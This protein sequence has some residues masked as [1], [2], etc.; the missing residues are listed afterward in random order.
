LQLPQAVANDTPLT[1]KVVWLSRQ[2][3]WPDYTQ[4]N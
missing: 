3:Q 1:T 4:A 2:S